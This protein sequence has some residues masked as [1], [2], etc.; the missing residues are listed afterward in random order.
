MPSKTELMTILEELKSKLEKE[1]DNAAYWHDLGV[2]Y[3]HLEEWDVAR[4]HLE[5]CLQFLKGKEAV[6]TY[7][8]LGTIAAETGLMNEAIDYWNKVIKL[9]PHNVFA[10]YSIAKAY[11]Y[12]EM[13]DAS[14]MHLRKADRYNSNRSLKIIYQTLAQAYTLKGEYDEARKTWEKVLL[15]DPQDLATI[16]EL[17]MLMLHMGDMAEAVAYCEKELA[18]GGKN[19]AI[20]YNCGL[21]HLSQDH[22]DEALE[23]FN[24]AIA[25]GMTDINI[26]VNIGEVYARQGNFEEAIRS[27]E[28]VL[29]EDP[30][31]IHASY[32]IG[33]IL[34]E[35]GLYERAIQAWRKTL[36]I[37]QD[38]LPAIV[39]SG[40]AH[41]VL[42]DY[43]KANQFMAI[44][45]ELAPKNAAI[46]G[47]LAEILLYMNQAEDALEEAL[48]AAILQ[49]TNPLAYV[50]AACAYSMLK[51]WEEAAIA[52]EQAYEL[53]QNV[54]MLTYNII[55]QKISEKDWQQIQEHQSE[56]AMIATIKKIIAQE[57]A[58]D[59][60]KKEAVANKGMSDLLSR[61][62]RRK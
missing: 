4:E 49:E 44:A 50:L 51:Q 8:H 7:Y 2:A 1:P 48:Q 45:K 36:A 14:I 56:P 47:N 27:W 60:E 58:L 24:K 43:T 16:H 20:Y 13:Y 61:L 32:N 54:F 46:R 10:H 25:N 17:S 37:K 22:Y 41:L 40:S 30:Q 38:Y 26:K 42:K 19:P 55:S 21:A 29:L 23:N 35:C 57:Q 59:D 3:M 5:H 33:M 28:E 53:D 52:F 31:N 11:L 12:R 62:L 9:D 34:Y 6:T 15:I 18:A 39:S